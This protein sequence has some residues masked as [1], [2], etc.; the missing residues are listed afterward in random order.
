M[1]KSRPLSRFW[2]QFER[3]RQPTA[4]NL[5]CGITAYDYDDALAL[6]RT[7]IF[8]A[9]GP[10]PVEICIRGIE[11]SSLEKNHVLPNIGDMNVR[12]IWF[13]LGYTSFEPMT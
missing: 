13:P 8:G 9:N 5:G 7:H 12:G 2:F 6:L 11:R 3:L 4:L 1:I 10:P